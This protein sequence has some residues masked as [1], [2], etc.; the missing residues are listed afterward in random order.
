MTIRVVEKL[1]MKA[2]SRFHGNGR[3]VI[4]FSISKSRTV[5][6]PLE[7]ETLCDETIPPKF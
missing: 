5:V 6:S 7:T 2:E 3:E 1:G 4:L